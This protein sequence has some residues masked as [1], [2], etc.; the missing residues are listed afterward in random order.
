MKVQIL[1]ILLK[2]NGLEALKW[3]QLWTN[4]S[5]CDLKSINLEALCSSCDFK[6]INEA[7]HCVVTSPDSVTS[8]LGV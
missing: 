2:A 8:Q 5:D 7:I 3:Q 6:R 4:K 1:S